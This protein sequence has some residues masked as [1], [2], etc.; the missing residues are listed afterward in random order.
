MLKPL[1]DKTGSE[2]YQHDQK[3]EEIF[4]VTEM[5]VNDH[6]IHKDG[7][8]EIITDFGVHFIEESGNCE[9][10]VKIHEEDRETFSF[11]LLNL[12]FEIVQICAW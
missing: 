5:Q 9:E 11:Q 8:D 4:T 10:N 3:N 12:L 7:N 6:P 2:L 1:A